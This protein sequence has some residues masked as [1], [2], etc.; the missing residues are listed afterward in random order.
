MSSFISGVT[1]YP[2]TIS[3]VA[4]IPADMI[5][6][7]VDLVLSRARLDLDEMGR[8]LA[9]RWISRVRWILCV[10]S[11]SSPLVGFNSHIEVGDST[12]DTRIGS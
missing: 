5:A 3:L 12:F 1:G 2:R 4:K 11:L 9:A 10:R 6:S 8:C 7:V